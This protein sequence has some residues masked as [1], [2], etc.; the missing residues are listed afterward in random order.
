MESMEEIIKDINERDQ[1]EIL[2]A[3]LKISNCI[4]TEIRNAIIEKLG[5]NANDFYNAG[6]D[7]YEHEKYSEAIESYSKAIELHSNFS[8]AYFNRGILLKEMNDSNN[9]CKNWQK[10]LDLKYQPAE[11]YITEFCK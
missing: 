8:E 4:P 5:A 3:F 2:N 6:N 7:L 10:A 1:Q 11:K 9:A